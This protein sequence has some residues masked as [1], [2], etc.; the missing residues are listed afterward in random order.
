MQVNITA[1]SHMDHGMTAAQ[2]EHALTALRNDTATLRVNAPGF[3][4]AEVT[5]PE[6][7]GTVPCA[8]LGPTTGG[9]PIPESETFQAKRGNRPN[10]SRLVRRPPTQSRVVTAI[11]VGGNLATVYGGPLAP[12]EPGDPFLNPEGR[13]ASEAFWN[14]HALSAEAF[15]L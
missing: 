2:R 12:Q 1:E 7:L 15:G 3:V 5:L 14:E 13:A 10:T 9:A 6:S 8:L 11:I 4:I